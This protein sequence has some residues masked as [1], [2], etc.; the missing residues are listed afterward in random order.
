MRFSDSLEE[1][2]CRVGIDE[3]N[4]RE[5][6]S[7]WISFSEELCHDRYEFFIVRIFDKVDEDEEKSI[8]ISFC[9]LFILLC[10][11]EL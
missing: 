6:I 11:L 4:K 8:I 1:V 7:R 9:F 5:Y 2:E 3:S 10:F